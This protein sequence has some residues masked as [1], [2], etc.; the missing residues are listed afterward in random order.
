VQNSETQSGQDQPGTD[1]LTLSEVAAYL[2]VPEDVVRE[3]V[4]KDGLPGQQIGGEWRFL[5]RAVADWLRFGP[6]F[7][8]EFRMFPPPWVFDHPFWE[9]L[10]QALEQRILSKIPALERR[11]AKPGSKEAVLGHFG[12]FQDDADLEE[13]VVAIR[14]RRQAGGE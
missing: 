5:K 2:R 14:A 12:V 6:H 4:E 13:Q 8:R 1:V 10:L 3:L 11:S 9:D 7:R